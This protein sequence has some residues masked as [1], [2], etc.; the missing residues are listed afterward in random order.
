MMYPGRSKDVDGD[1]VVSSQRALAG[2]IRD[3]PVGILHLGA[4]NRILEQDGYWRIGDLN[5]A[6]Q[7]RV[8]L[9]PNVGKITVKLIE[10]RLQALVACENSNGGIDY[11][12]YFSDIGIPLVPDQT[13]LNS[14]T[15]FLCSMPLAFSEVMEHF[16]DP[17][18]TMIFEERLSKFPR[19]RM[20]IKQ[21]KE[22]LRLDVSEMRLRQKEK[23][24]L[25]RLVDMLVY[26]SCSKR[27]FRF[28]PD[29]SH[30][31]RRASKAFAER[32]EITKEDFVCAIAS[33]WNVPQSLIVKRLP[34]ILVIMRGQSYIP[35]SEGGCG[36]F[37]K[38]I[39]SGVTS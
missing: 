35:R 25:R 8:R 37:R 38:L 31:W 24:L 17:A 14:G 3:L 28:H 20:S 19:E 30:W 29:F 22:E 39:R 5:D 7:D 26:D 10:S 4:K 34:T 11:E 9:I 12:Q 13:K 16:D 2:P 36:Q 23:G 21:I 6:W 27:D 32:N 15:E 18:L 1:F 33:E